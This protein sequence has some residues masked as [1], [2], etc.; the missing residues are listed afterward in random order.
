MMGAVGGA[1][2][3]VFGGGYLFLNSV[4]NGN[5][6]TVAQSE[7]VELEEDKNLVEKSDGDIYAKLALKQ[8]Q[9]ELA[10][11]NDLE[12]IDNEDVTEEI[13]KPQ[14]DKT[15][16][17]PAPKTATKPKPTP[18]R[19]ARNT[20]PP[21]PVRKAT[22]RR[23]ATPVATRR[24]PAPRRS[25]APKPQPK[26]VRQATPQPKG[27][28]KV[29]KSISRPP[30]VEKDPLAELNRLRNIGSFGKINYAQASN[31]N[32]S[33]TKETLVASASPMYETPRERRL[34]RRKEMQV[35]NVLILQQIQA[36]EQLGQTIH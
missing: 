10:K 4:F 31:K 21:R 8:Q 22:P 30:Q 16:N 13:K 6:A 19:V 18:R 32:N 1:F 28:N 5:S 11:L 33:Q 15:P 23:R 9:D 34:R 17:K 12:E 36:P 25:A 3:L 27:V 2:F 29:A 14:Q 35:E 20:S 26:P 7:E 24:T